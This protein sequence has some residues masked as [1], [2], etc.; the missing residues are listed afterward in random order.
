MIQET[1]NS[2]NVFAPGNLRYQHGIDAGRRS[3]A[4][5]VL[6]P[7]GIETVYSYHDFASTVG[8]FA[9][10][11]PNC[12]SRIRF[13][14]G[15]YGVLQVEDHHVRGQRL[16]LFQR[17]GVGAGNVQAGTAWTGMGCISHDT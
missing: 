14:I 6:S 4:Q 11:D 7:L 10:R 13:R 5:I 12:V 17:P 9:D 16:R 15:R 3:H 2:A 8:S 1:I